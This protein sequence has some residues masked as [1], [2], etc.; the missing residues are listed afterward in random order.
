VSPQSRGRLLQLRQ[1]DGCFFTITEPHNAQHTYLVVGVHTKHGH[2]QDDEGAHYLQACSD[3]LIGGPVVEVGAAWG[4]QWGRVLGTKPCNQLGCDP[5]PPPPT[6]LQLCRLVSYMRCIKSVCS[7]M[8]RMT[9][10]PLQ[11]SL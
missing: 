2:S 11:D 3:P 8:L 4:E 10:M 6:Y 9:G 1:G 7:P 5:A